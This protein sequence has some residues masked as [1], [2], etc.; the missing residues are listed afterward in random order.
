MQFT[1]NLH[2]N[3]SRSTR[4]NSSSVHTYIFR[5][6]YF[7]CNSTRVCD[8]KCNKDQSD[9]IQK[10]R[11]SSRPQTV[12]NYKQFLEEY[13]DAPPTP[14]RKKREIDL[15]RK[16]SKQWIA[17]DKFRSKFVTKP[18]HLPR[19][20]RNKTAKKNPE[21]ISTPTADP[22]PSTS[23]KPA[24]KLKTLL[25]PATSAETQEAIEA[26]LMLG[27]MPTLE[28]NPGDNASLVPITGA[29]P[30]D[31][32]EAWQEDETLEP[33]PTNQ[34]LD[35]GI[36]TAGNPPLG[37]V[38]GTAIKS[39]D[40]NDNDTQEVKIE[41]KD[42]NIKQYGIKRKYK[43]DRK[44]KCKLCGEKLSSVQEFNQHCLDN[45][46]PLPCPDCARIFISPQTL[47]KHRYTHA[48]YMY[49]WADCGHGFTFKSQLESH[50]K[51]HLKMAGFV[52]FK[53]KCRKRFKRESE[54]NAHLIVHDK[55][56]IKCDHCDYSNP[57]IRNVR[58]HMKV[59]SDRLPYHCPICQKGF[60]WQQ[61][62]RRHLATCN[63]Y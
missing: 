21:A 7:A 56:E 18:T 40:K 11:T 9:E 62:K 15:K 54:L 37:I 42:L 52:C 59:H 19:P 13:A 47:A 49:E 63:G 6:F 44:F 5:L 28:N 26:L 17:A 4:I 25:T 34:T 51:V 53:P 32:R 2:S 55:K 30:D 50:R 3:V 60:K 45:H 20:V 27:V 24:S 31:I 46:P 1:S 61:Q 8:P 58:A 16:P 43:L 41:K 35:Q 36:N 39:D 22:Q 23:D 10:V 48:E 38:I 57:D 12:I 33:P 29:A 14:P